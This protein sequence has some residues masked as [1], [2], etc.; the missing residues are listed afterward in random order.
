MIFANIVPHQVTFFKVLSYEHFLIIFTI[1]IIILSILYFFHRTKPEK[2]EKQKQQ[3]VN[4][5]VYYKIDEFILPYIDQKRLPLTLNLGS[6]TIKTGQYATKPSFIVPSI[7]GTIKEEGRRRMSM[8]YEHKGHEPKYIGSNALSERSILTFR[9]PLT[10]DKDVKMED[11][12]IFFKKIMAHH[13]TINHELA[14]GADL[15]IATPTLMN[16]RNK[17]KL[18]D[19]I[20]SNTDLNIQHLLLISQPSC[21][22]AS[23]G[24]LTGLVVD[25]GHANCN[26]VPVYEGCSIEYAAH[27]ND[28]GGR[29]L[30]EILH[31]MILAN[32]GKN[33]TTTTELQ[34]IR[35]VKERLCYVG[36]TR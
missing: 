2:K 31:R 19:L 32:Q 9:Y 26:A 15:V 10:K 18:A 23:R 1:L 29:V 3:R 30:D 13:A 36:F 28:I 24:L 12:D 34:I 8:L 25:C 20:F 7:I 35:E 5:V 21:V 4:Q 27:E 33:W 6:F 17:Y 22:L 16:E 11:Y 14:T